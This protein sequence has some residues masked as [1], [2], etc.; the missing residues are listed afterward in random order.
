MPSHDAVAAL[1]V[2]GAGPAATNLMAIEF[3]WVRL[4]DDTALAPARMIA[5]G[6]VNWML[7]EAGGDFAAVEDL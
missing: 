3:P 6:Q 5:Y 4:L 2:S 7:K 1:P